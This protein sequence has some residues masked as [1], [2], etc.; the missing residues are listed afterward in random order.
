MT[1]K[2]IGLALLAG[3]LYCS[4]IVVETSTKPTPPLKFYDVVSKDLERLKKKGVLPEE[5]N[6]IRK[7]DYYFGEKA[8]ESLLGRKLPIPE[9]A[10]GN[11]LL[12]LE[13]IDAPDDADP[14]LILQMSMTDLK[15]KN[16]AWELGRTYSTGNFQK[17]TK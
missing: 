6:S 14:K 3:A 11:Y 12:E 16:K 13:F 17:K 8:H 15:S 7:V 4:W 9:I 5:W 1:Y 2:I 10:T